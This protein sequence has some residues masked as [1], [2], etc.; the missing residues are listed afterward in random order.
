MTSFSDQGGKVAADG[1]SAAVIAGTATVRA[2]SQPA[3]RNLLAEPRRL[4]T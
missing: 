2:S 1:M 4:F 3:A